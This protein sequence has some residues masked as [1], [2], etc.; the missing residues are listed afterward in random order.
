MNIN[1][2]RRVGSHRSERIRLNRKIALAVRL[3]AALLRKCVSACINFSPATDTASP[4]RSLSLESRASGFFIYGSRKSRAGSP[5]IHGLRF[6]RLSVYYIRPS[7]RETMV[8]VSLR[9]S[10][11]PRFSPARAVTR[12]MPLIRGSLVGPAAAVEIEGVP[13]ITVQ[14]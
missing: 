9:T 4:R 5:I 7:G 13:V 10:V 6:V 1:R 11:C 8:P 3:V 14:S 12:E 2:R